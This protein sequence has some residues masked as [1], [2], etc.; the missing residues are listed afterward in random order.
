ME[1]LGILNM[2]KPEVVDLVHPPFSAGRP[3]C[4]KNGNRLVPSMK[5]GR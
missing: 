2:L 3:S 4:L 5:L 1:N